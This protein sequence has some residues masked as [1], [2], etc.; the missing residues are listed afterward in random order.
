MNSQS[1]NHHY[2]LVRLAR[3]HGIKQ[4]EASLVSMD[5]RL[6]PENRGHLFEVV[7][8]ESGT[9]DIPSCYEELIAAGKLEKALMERRATGLF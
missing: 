8:N 1:E 4:L 6:Y 5:R 7:T 3:Q 2:L 9:T